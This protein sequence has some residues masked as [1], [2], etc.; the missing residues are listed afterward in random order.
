MEREKIKKYLIKT[1]QFVEYLQKYIKKY[2]ERKMRGLVVQDIT[3]PLIN[4][5]EIIK[6]RLRKVE[7]WVDG[8][9]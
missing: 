2:R 7:D 6:I 9:G 8:I 1:T 4:S 3:I 5:L